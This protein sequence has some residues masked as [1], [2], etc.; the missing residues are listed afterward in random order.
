MASATPAFTQSY[1]EREL[2]PTP[3]G[4]TVK[5]EGWTIVANADG[6][7]FTWLDLRRRV[8]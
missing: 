2:S 7:R 8:I 6:T 3:V 1:E 4:Q 5:A